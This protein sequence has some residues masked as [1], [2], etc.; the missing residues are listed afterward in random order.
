MRNRSWAILIAL[1]LCCSMKAP[2]DDSGKLVTQRFKLS[3]AQPEDIELIL[4]VKR[5]Y[6]LGLHA[7]EF[8]SSVPRGIDW[9]LAHNSQHVLEVRGTPDAL[10]EFR[11]LLKY[12][13]VKPKSIRMEI[14]VIR[15]TTA[16]NGVHET[17]TVASPTIEARNNV[18]FSIEVPDNYTGQTVRL[19]ISPS[20]AVGNMISVYGQLQQITA[21]KTTVRSLSGRQR[22]KLGDN[23]F[24]IG[25]VDVPKS[26]S[27]REGAVSSDN[28]T[29]DR[30]GYAIEVK[31]SV[32][33]AQKSG[34]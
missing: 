3:Q 30:L 16:S 32:V 6:R 13:D 27:V 11:E 7:N 9:I 1:G 4:G 26:K 31:C 18:P 19:R 34:R 24:L 14:R 17:V 25:E 12:L 28:A 29:L 10:A 33:T 23:A 15:S 20:L 21:D 2:A 5:D 22:I 8:N